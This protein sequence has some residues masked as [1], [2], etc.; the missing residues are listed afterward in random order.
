MSGA[1]YYN[2]LR[3]LDALVNGRAPAG[4]LSWTPAPKEVPACELAKQGTL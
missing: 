2:L 4:D 3:E 1:T